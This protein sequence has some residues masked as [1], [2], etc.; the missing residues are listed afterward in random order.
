VLRVLFVCTGNSAR[1]QIAEALLA[2]HGVGAFAA[3][4]AGSHPAERVS[5]FAVEVL[6]EHGI[7]WTGRMPRSVD[8]VRDESWDVVITVCDHAKEHCPVFPGQPVVAHWGLADPAS[9]EGDDA[10]RRAAFAKTYAVLEKRIQRL[11]ALPFAQLDAAERAAAVQA[12]G[13]G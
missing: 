13:N 8:A 11:A 2:R 9:V 12:I 3:A 10:A 7:D 6:K 4:S 1:S 5:R